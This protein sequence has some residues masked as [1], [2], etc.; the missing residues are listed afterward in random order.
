MDIRG[1]Q[2]LKASPSQKACV[3]S[4][5]HWLTHVPGVCTVLLQYNPSRMQF[6]GQRILQRHN[7]DMKGA[8]QYSTYSTVLSTRT[9]C[10]I[11]STRVPKMS[12]HFSFCLG[13]WRHKAQGTAW[14]FFRSGSSRFDN[15]ELVSLL[16]Y[17]TYRVRNV[18]FFILFRVL[19]SYYS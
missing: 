1:E 9:A 18:M 15:V 13:K 5:P 19:Y 10:Q 3:H 2:I 6:T 17:S 12:A 11:Y 14:S 8:L 7:A 4:L 16:Q